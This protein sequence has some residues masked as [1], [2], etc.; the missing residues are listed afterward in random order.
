MSAATDPW[1]RSDHDPLSLTEAITAA[2]TSAPPTPSPTTSPNTA[3]PTER[4]TS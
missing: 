4:H 3:D 2:A 1:A